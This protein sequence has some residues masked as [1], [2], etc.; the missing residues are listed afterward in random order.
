M[1]LIPEQY[2][3]NE[4]LALDNLI[5]NALPEEHLALDRKVAREAA[6]LSTGTVTCA[7]GMLSEKDFH[8]FLHE[9]VA[10]ELERH[11][12]TRRI[13]RAVLNLALEGDNWPVEPVVPQETLEGRI[14]Q[15][16]TL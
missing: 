13:F 11:A 5:E 14:M 16:A 9:R 3:E 8:S 1:S 10:P 4:V 12:E 2:D 6:W 7:C 15:A